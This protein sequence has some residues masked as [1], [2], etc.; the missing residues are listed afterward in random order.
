MAVEAAVRGLVEALAAVV[1][2]VAATQSATAVGI[3]DG[4]AHSV[5]R[6][7]EGAHQVV[8]AVSATQSRCYTA[9][10]SSS[11]RSSSPAAAADFVQRRTLA[12][13]CCRRHSQSGC[14]QLQ[15]SFHTSL[16]AYTITNSS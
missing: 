10:Y 16:H 14:C 6:T 11:F 7:V 12:T 1:G 8:V 13:Y 9:A 4:A 2:D 15:M 5:V 3:V